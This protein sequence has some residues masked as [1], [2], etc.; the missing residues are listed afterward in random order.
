MNKV[1][2]DFE[3]NVASC[4]EIIEFGAVKLNEKDE[5]ISE[6]SSYVLPQK[7]EITKAT[8]RLTGITQNK[9]SKAPALAEVLEDFLHWIGDDFEYIY[10]WS[11][12]DYQCLVDECKEKGIEGEALTSV[13][14]RW[15]DF[16]REFGDL[17]N[18]EGTLSLKNAISAIDATFEGL[19]HSALVDAR[20]TAN[21]FA[22]AHNP[23]KRKNW[24]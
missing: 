14:D 21:L 10:S 3:M 2:V 4:R 6:F 22:V 24:M 16:Q 23:V 11:M 9:V 17:I 7:Q 1:I 12:T 15:K 20:N 13:F 18:Y 19:Q 5:I 8:T